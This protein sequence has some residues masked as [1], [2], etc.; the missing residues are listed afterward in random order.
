MTTVIV[1]F[2][3]DQ[4]PRPDKLEIFADC[5]HMHIGKDQKKMKYQLDF[6]PV[7]TGKYHASVFKIMASRK[8]NKTFRFLMA[9][10]NKPNGN[11]FICATE[12]YSL[13]IKGRVKII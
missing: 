7:F 6:G 2:F 9:S 11:Q 13:P 3:T 12:F 4:A 5:I 8:D 10:Y 1:S